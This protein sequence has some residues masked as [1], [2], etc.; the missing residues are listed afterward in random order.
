MANVPV[1]LTMNGT[2]I[3]P[4]PGQGPVGPQGP[5]GPQ[6]PAGP[7]GPA[8]PPGLSGGADSVFYTHPSMR[9]VDPDNGSDSLHGLTPTGAKKTIQAAYDAVPINL[10]NRNGVPI[11]DR[12]GGTVILMPGRH[13]V[14]PGVKMWRS[15]PCVVAGLLPTGNPRP[16]ISGGRVVNPGVIVYSDQQPQELFSIGLDPLDTG[17]N[18]YGYVFQDFHYELAGSTKYVIHGIQNN[19]LTVRNIAGRHTNPVS[20]NYAIRVVNASDTTGADA[21]WGR[22]HNNWTHGTGLL[23]VLATSPQGLNVNQWVVRDNV[24]HGF[25]G[26]TS[27]FIYM[28]RAIG[29]TIAD[30]NLETAAI[31]IE[32][33]GDSGGEN[34]VQNHLRGNNGEGVAVWLKADRLWS[35]RMDDMYNRHPAE[36]DIIAN[37]G[38]NTGHN[39]ITET[40]ST[41]FNNL[42]S[43]NP[44]TDAGKGNVFL[45][46]TKLASL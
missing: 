24:C 12:Q 13:D 27:P 28:E 23:Q 35:S 26:M 17:H 14:G 3:V 7:K 11:A 6:G 4:D 44:W 29:C 45:D 46:P 10:T 9:F 21:S 20:G 1:T 2:A 36:G 19:A 15:K 30:N 32:F 38:A 41:P 33:G 22:I 43:S 5:T 31:A 34:N 39:I 18:S 25:T 40:V 37:L 16:S 42:Y 8:G